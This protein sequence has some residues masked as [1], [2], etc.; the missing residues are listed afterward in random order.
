MRYQNSAGESLSIPRVSY[1][2]SGFAL[3]RPDGSWLEL[4]NHVAWMDLERNRSSLRIT[5]ASPGVYHSIRFHVGLDSAVNHAEATRFPADK[6][7]GVMGGGC[8]TTGSSGNF[9]SDKKFELV[10][11]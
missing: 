8:A 3:E 7:S 4:T 1:L 11:G 2:L 6:E 9:G 5:N 10:K